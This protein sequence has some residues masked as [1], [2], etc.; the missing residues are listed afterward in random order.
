MIALGTR[1]LLIVEQ[2]FTRWPVGPRLS[3]LLFAGLSPSA[4]EL[5]TARHRHRPPAETHHAK[6]RCLSDS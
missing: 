2:V 6:I 1:A 3:G 4:S 5:G